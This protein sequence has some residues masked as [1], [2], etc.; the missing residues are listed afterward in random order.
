MQV[1]LKY[2]VAAGLSLTLA[3]FKGRIKVKLL[4]D[5]FSLTFRPFASF[6][7]SINFIRI[8]VGQFSSTFASRVHLSRYEQD[9][10]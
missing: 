1:Y 8:C 7:V 5:L 3:W 9:K 4:E 10:N 2:K 6:L